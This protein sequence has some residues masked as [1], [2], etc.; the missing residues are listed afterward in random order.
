MRRVGALYVGT[1]KRKRG[2]FGMVERK[3]DIKMISK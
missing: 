2:G 3:S 1:M